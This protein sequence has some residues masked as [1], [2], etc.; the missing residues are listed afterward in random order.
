MYFLNSHHLY[1]GTEYNWI[2][3]IL[4]TDFPNV[5]LIHQKKAV[6]IYFNLACVRREGF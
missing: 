5:N 1:S 4:V 2:V 3:G 6:H